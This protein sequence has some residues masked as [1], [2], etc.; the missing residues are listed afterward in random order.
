[1][2]TATINPIQQ[3][4][5]TAVVDI[6]RG[7]ALLGVVIMNYIEFT[8][9]NTS[10]NFRPK[11][12][13]WGQVTF[14]ILDIF[15]EAKSWTLLSVLFGYG[16]AVL[17][18][19]LQS[20]GHNAVKFFIKRMFWL[21]VIAFINSCFFFGDILK[22][23]A[24]MG[25]FLLFFYHSSGKFTLILAL[26]IIFISPV[27]G[28]LVRYIHYDFVGEF[29][30]V[31]PLFHSNKIYEVFIFNLKGTYVRQVLFP[32]YAINCHLI[33]FAC[34]LL[35]FSAYRFN[36]FNRLAGLKKYIKRFFWYSLAVS[37]LMT[38]I[39]LIS[40]YFNYWAYTNYYQPYFIGVLSTMV[41]IATSICWLYISGRCAKVFKA[42][43]YIGR[44]TLTNYLVQNIISMLVFSGAGLGVYDTWHPALYVGFA[45]SI[46]CIQVFFS[47][48]W[49][50]H[51]YYGPVEW[52]WRQL[53]YGKRLPI[54]QTGAIQLPV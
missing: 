13:I 2:Q 32:F 54:K 24:L 42:F 6:L 46:Y 4:Q 34:M 19:N 16:F 5:R 23:Y 21:F 17:I 49:L 3:T 53:S 14:K 22:D 37:L 12:D 44:M 36:I 30:R 38:A 47:R 48:W 26:V 11:T 33:I 8:R 20:K 9:F 29:N 50:K 35:G 41:F 43:Q 25:L 51:Y 10:I 15:F 27:L 45:V 28:L 40:S 1:M 52:L 7:W 18:N 31:I 39:S